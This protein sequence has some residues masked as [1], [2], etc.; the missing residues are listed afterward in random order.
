MKKEE[1]TIDSIL[2]RLFITT[3]KIEERS[4]AARFNNDLSISELHV[5]REIGIDDT[6]TMTQVANGLKISVG[7]LTTAMN[8]LE[9]KGYVTRTR[10]I[11]DR[12]IVNLCLTERGRDAFD[13]HEAFH[14][15]MVDAAISG[16]TPK[17]KGIILKALSQLDDFF[18]REWEKARSG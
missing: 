5:I 3:L 16:L 10:D 2:T 14:K 11:G 6:K 7:A 4:I 12:R 15:E 1:K 17:E 13:I 8:K 9:Q 18:I